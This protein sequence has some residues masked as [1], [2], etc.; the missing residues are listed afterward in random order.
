MG[1][2]L[3]RDP[4]G[5]FGGLPL[6]G[7]MNNCPPN[8]IDPVGQKAR[9]QLDPAKC[10]ITVT[11]NI[12]IYGSGASSKM[13]SQIEESIV[14]HW[15]GH[16]TRRGCRDQDPGNCRVVVA[17][18]VLYYGNASHWWDVPQ[19]NQIHIKNKKGRSW[20]MGPGGSYGR[21]YLDDP[22]TWAH[23][24]GHLLGL[25]DDY[26]DNLLEFLGGGSTITFPGHKG[27]MMGQYDGRVVQH[28][29]DGIL[30]G[31]RC[32]RSCCCPSA[33]QPHQ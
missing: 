11:L 28:E 15:N 18:N 14:Q 13:A 22:W 31:A 19:D 3:N 6:Y 5:L 20:V 26:I 29:I 33:S 17:A 9:V 2:W 16:T 32:P 4:I 7:A 27:H 8:L 25:F 10:R 21:W 24:A 30:Q 1:R 23:E 12:G